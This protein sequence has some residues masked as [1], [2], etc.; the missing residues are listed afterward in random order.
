M[1][2]DDW[3]PS[4]ENNIIYIRSI[5]SQVGLPRLKTE[6]A[7]S[8]MSSNFPLE[9]VDRRISSNLLKTYRTYNDLS[10]GTGEDPPSMVPPLSMYLYRYFRSPG[11]E[12][13]HSSCDLARQL[14]SSS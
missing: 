13:G 2:L 1:F 11:C 5:S 6:D 4:L 14:L 10:L 9:S 3:N 7:E 12:Q 8:L